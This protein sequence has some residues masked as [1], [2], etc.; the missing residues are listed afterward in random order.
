M[1]GLCRTEFA[2]GRLLLGG[3]VRRA[4]LDINFCCGVD[5]CTDQSGLVG[6]SRSPVS[7]GGPHVLI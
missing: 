4:E 7:S 6:A 2:R 5:N 3:L 1:D